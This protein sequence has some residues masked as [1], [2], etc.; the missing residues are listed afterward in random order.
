MYSKLH[1]VLKIVVEWLDKNIDVLEVPTQQIWALSREYPSDND[2]EYHLS[3]QGEEDPLETTAR[4]TPKIRSWF[5]ES[6]RVGH[7]LGIGYEDFGYL[8]GLSEK[9]RFAEHM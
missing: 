1:N 4:L 7:E 6:N 2:N 8:D 5:M 3:D 9:K